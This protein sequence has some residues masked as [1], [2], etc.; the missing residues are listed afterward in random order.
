MILRSFRGYN[1]PPNHAGD[2][3]D[4]LVNIVVAVF[5]FL[6]SSPVANSA[7]WVGTV[8]SLIVLWNVRTIR[9]DFLFT[10]RLPQLLDA[11]Q[12]NASNLSKHLNDFDSNADSIQ[13]ELTTCKANLNSLVQKLHGSSKK[14][15]KK[16]ALAVI[17][18]FD[19]FDNYRNTFSKENVRRSYAQL[20]GLIQDLQNL[21]EDQKWSARDAG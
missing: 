1:A 20:N 19:R 2:F 14:R 3:V 5:E 17:N 11:L 13:I 6:T 18:D 9:I 10:A 4:K 7:T 12:E 8:A 21:R 15:I 16:A